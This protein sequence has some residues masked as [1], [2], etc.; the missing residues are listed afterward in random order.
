MRG[1]TLSAMVQMF[2]LE[3][4][5]AI[6]LAQGTQTREHVKH[7]LNR[8]QETLYG[9]FDWPF[10][11]IYREETF[12]PGEVRYSWPDDMVVEDVRQLWDRMTERYVPITYGITMEDRNTRSV[13]E[14]SDPALKW[15]IVDARQYEIWPTPAA[16]RKGM[17]EGYRAYV[18][19]SSED[20]IC[21]LDDNLIVLYAA[22]EWL[23]RNKMPDATAKL[24]TAKRLR[25]RLQGR[26]VSDKRRNVIPLVA[27][28]SPDA[29]YLQ[30]PR[31]VYGLPPP[32][33]R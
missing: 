18:K 21:I 11:H 16:Q 20:D 26:L 10:L 7:A 31:R 4:G 22:A 32:I 2:R 23:A 8:V 5:Q 28:Q 14:R 1:T 30:L 19:L 25:I 13:G 6:Q 27:G 9:D 33:P 12:Q 29:A 17:I 3:T 24:E 15:L